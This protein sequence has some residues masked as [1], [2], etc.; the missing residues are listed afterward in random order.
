MSRRPTPT[1]S[2]VL[3]LMREGHSFDYAYDQ[4]GLSVYGHNKAIFLSRLL[5]AGF[6][7]VSVNPAVDTSGESRVN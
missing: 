5:A 7:Q 1:Q 3:R 6:I 4:A 2:L